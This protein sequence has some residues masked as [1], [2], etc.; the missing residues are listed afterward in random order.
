MKWLKR[1][2]KASALK[3]W[4]EKEES[5]ANQKGINRHFHGFH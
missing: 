3:V 5:I 2:I 4:G 1:G